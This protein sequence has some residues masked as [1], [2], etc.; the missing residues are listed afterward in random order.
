MDSVSNQ[1]WSFLCPHTE[2]SCWACHDCIWNLT[3]RC[4]SLS[5]LETNVSTTFTGQLLKSLSFTSLCTLQAIPVARY[6]DMAAGGTLSNGIVSPIASLLWELIESLSG[7]TCISSQKQQAA[8]DVQASYTPWRQQHVDKANSPLRWHHD[9]VCGTQ[10]T[11]Y[12]ISL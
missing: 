12:H 1:L 11:E 7:C 5:F 6:S 4:H 8:R 9:I 10:A 3:Y 2:A